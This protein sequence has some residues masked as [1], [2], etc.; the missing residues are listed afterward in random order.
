MLMFELKAINS[1]WFANYFALYVQVPWKSIQNPFDL[2]DQGL[3]S[4][5]SIRI[6]MVRLG[7]EYIC[8]FRPKVDGF[9]F[10]LSFDELANM[11]F[12]LIL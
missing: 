11:F 6:H 8:T 7:V 12:F 2:G 1:A 5:E 3:K 9:H 10:K 4:S